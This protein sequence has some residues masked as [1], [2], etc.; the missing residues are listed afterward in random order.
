RDGRL[1]PRGGRDD[2]RAD[3]DREHAGHGLVDLQRL[4]CPLGEHRGGAARGPG[5]RHALPRPVPGGVPPVLPDLRGEH[6]GRAGPPPAQE[7]V[8]VPVS[9]KA[10]QLW[11]GGEAFIWLTG[12]AL[13]LSLLLVGGLVA[14]IVYNGLGF[15]WPT[16]VVRLTLRDGK[17]LTGQLVDREPVPAEPGEYRIKLQVANRDLY[18]ADFQWVDEARIAR[19]EFPRDVVVVERTEWGLLIGTVKELRDGGTVVARGPEAGLAELRRRLPEAA[20]LRAELRRIEKGD[21]G[22]VNYAQETTRL[23]LRR[24]E[25][26]GITAGPEV[27]AI[28]KRNADLQV[29][30]AAHEARLGEVRR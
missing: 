6:G 24:L 10:S 3:G 15:F 4:P 20:R 14:L 27:D 26:R 23:A 8:P 30:Y 1:R 12:G 19:R 11:R 18:G 5:G 28:Q 17:T 13:A 2:D 16:N 21:I 25:L 29:R 7:E 9:G 22:A